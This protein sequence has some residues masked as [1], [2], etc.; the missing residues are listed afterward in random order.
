MVFA[1]IFLVISIYVPVEIWKEEDHYADKSH[2]YMENIFHA[3]EFYKRLTGEFNPDAK[4]AVQVVDAIRDSLTADSTYLNDQ[5]LHLKGKSLPVT[6]PEGYDAEFDTTFGFRKTR[7]DTILDTTVTL[8][9]FDPEINRVD[10]VYI[11]K[12]ELKKYRDD[13]N[14][15]EILAETPMTRVEVNTYYDSYLPDTNMLYC[16]LTGK[17]YQVTISEDGNFRVSS[18]I[19]GVYKE[20]RYGIFSF[21]AKNH[22]YIEDGVRSWEKS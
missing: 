2:F 11:Q 18:P 12:R 22:G 9:V 15:R 21:K 7:R 5:V 6:V 4:W 14:L 3:E 13:P 16:P 17:P 19:E 8:L 20:P 1:F 10:T